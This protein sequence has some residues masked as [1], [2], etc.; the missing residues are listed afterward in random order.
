MGIRAKILSGFLILSTMLLVAGVWTVFQ[1]RTMGQS[2]QDL[3]D[4]NYRSVQAGKAMLEAL[5]R[6]DSGVLLLLLGEE[7]EGRAILAAADEVFLENLGF[8]EGNITIDGEAGCLQALRASYDAYRALWSAPPAAA[9]RAS[10]LE[11]YSGPVQAAFQRTKGGVSELMAMNDRGIYETASRMQAQA[12]RAAMPGVVAILSAV[13][14]SLLFSSFV[15][16][17]MVRPLLRIARAAEEFAERGKAFDVS[18]GTGDEIDQLATTVRE[19]TLK[20]RA[21]ASR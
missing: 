3:L 21:A 19:L 8:A 11:W 18:P 16:A 17:Y 20:S 12:R 1:L 13:V 5:E 14:F 10:G 15:H 7:A 6:E 9:G 4:D 2:V